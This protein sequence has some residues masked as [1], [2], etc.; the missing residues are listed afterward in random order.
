MLLRDRG[1]CGI[2]E[3]T[4]LKGCLFRA[5]ILDT[6]A[7]WVE[8][9]WDECTEGASLGGWVRQSFGTWPGE[10]TLR[11]TGAHREGFICHPLSPAA[12]A[13]A[14]W[15]GVNPEEDSNLWHGVRARD[16]SLR[17]WAGGF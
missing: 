9:V 13:A 6:S 2:K 8:T 15:R 1:D 10:P 12:S 7:L 3:S 17:R 5:L 14:Q 16:L 11:C 4:R